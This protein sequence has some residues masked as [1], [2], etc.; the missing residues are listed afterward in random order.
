MVAPTIE[1]TTPAPSIQELEQAMIAA[2]NAGDT[3]SA[4]ILANE[5]AK[6]QSSQSNVKF[7]GKEALK[8]FLPDVYNEAKN[9]VGAI[10]QPIETAKG[11]GNLSLG[12]V[13]KLLPNVQNHEKY[14]DALGEYFANKYGS[15]DAFLTTLQEHPAS[16]LSDASMF[17]TGGATGAAKVASLAKAGKATSFLEKVAQTGTAIDPLNAVLNTGMYGASKVIP[18][19]VAPKLYESAAKWSTTLKPKERAAITETALKNQVPLNYEG[20]GKVQSKLGELGN[21]MNDLIATA[22]ENNVKI[23]ATTVLQNLQDVRQS[24]GGF[25]IE[26]GTDIKELNNIEKNFRTYLRK[27]KIKEVTPQQL[28][29]FKSDAYK[30]IDFGRAPEKPSV[31]KEEAYRSMANLA[32]TSLENFIPELKSV[33]TKYGALRELQPNLQKSVGRIENRDILGIGSGVKAGAGAAIGGNIG[34][35]LGLAESIL[36]MPKVK[37]KAALELYKKQNQGLGMFLD[38]NARNTLLRQ[39]LDQQ[40]QL[41]SQYPSLLGNQ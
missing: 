28:Q 4:T 6:L 2:H 1:V 21:R 19:T 27:N 41:N 37:S 9:V 18:T 22:T 11:I 39:A 20:L 26:G 5:I 33:N 13:E 23:S 24:L 16:V 32:K 35:G 34:A 12:L 25:K 7:S 29:D 10:T 3:Q 17:L 8:N 36:E 15:K 14:A 38:N 31:A 40:F 30:R